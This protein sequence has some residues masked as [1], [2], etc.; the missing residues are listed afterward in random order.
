MTELERYIELGEI[1]IGRHPITNVRRLL[2]EQLFVHSQR[3]KEISIEF[4]VFY[5]DD[6]GAVFDKKSMG[7]Y[8]VTLTADTKTF[9]N[10][11]TME[12]LT[13][14]GVSEYDYFVGVANNPVNIFQVRL[15]IIKLRAS[16]GKFDN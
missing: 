14:G 16:Q 4:K 5:M 15:N 6:S 9:I 8:D 13:E 1:E 3:T 10:P 11:Q 7:S 12:V 2:K